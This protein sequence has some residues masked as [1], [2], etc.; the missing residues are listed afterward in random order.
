MRVFFNFFIKTFAFLTAVTFFFILFGF[1]IS[2]LES[3]SST[4]RTNIN[5]FIFK[6][7]DNTSQNKIVLIELRGPILN[8]PSGALE[9][10]LID[11]I[12]VIYVSEFI[13]DLE[14]IKLQNP[15]GIVISI[16]SPGGSVSATYNLYN[17]IEK[18][19]NNNKTKI[20]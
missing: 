13:K 19:K 2:N 17:A 8:K 3:F 12:E 15:K 6:E 14:E 11:N 5:K 1:L 16:D 9:F 7:G 10:S 20:F 4:E 18:F